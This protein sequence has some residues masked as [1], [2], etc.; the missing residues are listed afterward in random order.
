M[1]YN[2]KLVE[3]CAMYVV[4]KDMGFD[5]AINILNNLALF[6]HTNM[7]LLDYVASKCYDNIDILKKANYRQIQTLIIALS[8]ADYKPVFWDTIKE[9]LYRDKLLI[10][11]IS[12]KS[13]LAI[14]LAILD[15]YWPK[16]LEKVFTNTYLVK[17]KE[18]K[19]LLF[20]NSIV[21][22]HYRDY[23]GPWPS[24]DVISSLRETISYEK[25]DFPLKNALELATGGEQYI[26]TNIDTKLGY[27]LGGFD[28]FF[29]LKNT[30]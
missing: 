3:E 6:P 26:S 13:K 1:F 16:L 30:R 11:S 19:R 4:A 20:L 25:Y 28:V 29:K 27:F 7:P 10:G 24:D 9:Y 5:V 23:E 8:I 14:N 18:R 22:N 15:C 12:E 21:K 2:E 17:R